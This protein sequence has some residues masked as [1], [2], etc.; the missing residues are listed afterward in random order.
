MRCRDRRN[1]VLAGTAG[2]SATRSCTTDKTTFLVPLIN[3]ECSTA[4]GEGTTF[5]ELSACAKGFADDFTHLRLKVDGR[6]VGNLKSLRVQ[7]ESTFTSV[8]GNVFGI[9]PASNSKFAADG[10]WALIT[11]TP[12]QHT[13][14]FGGFYRPFDFRPE[15]TYHLL[16]QN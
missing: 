1:L 14:T 16:V 7:A 5:V 6:A 4:E 12:G 3:V 2:G 13:I 8:D 11:L 10:Y 9:P 15:A